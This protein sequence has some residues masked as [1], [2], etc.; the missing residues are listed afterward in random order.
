MLSALWDVLTFAVIQEYWV[1]LQAPEHE[2]K[3]Y[4]SGI[5]CTWRQGIFYSHVITVNLKTKGKK[6]V[7]LRNV[8]NKAEEKFILLNTS[9]CTEVF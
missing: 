1:N 3:K 7:S 8:V 5:Y 4:S 2:Q 6:S 9:P